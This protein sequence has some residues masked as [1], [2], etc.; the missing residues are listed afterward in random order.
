[1]TEHE[2]TLELRVASLQYDLAATEKER[3]I[4]RSGWD[5]A[6]KD[7]GA[8]EAE[9]K[10]LRE[11]AGFFAQKWDVMQPVNSDRV[12]ED[13][14]E[15]AMSEKKLSDDIQELVTAAKNLVD[16]LINE[17]GGTEPHSLH[18]IMAKRNTVQALRPFEQGKEWG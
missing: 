3:N 12:V 8:A 10:R 6:E 17:V 13:F 2:R 16:A 7:A 1:M 15:L 14:K 9:V 4:A 18:I 11:R 5:T